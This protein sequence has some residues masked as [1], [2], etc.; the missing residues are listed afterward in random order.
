LILGEEIYLELLCPSFPWHQK[1]E[2][3]E[4]REVGTKR[5]KKRK[6]TEINQEVNF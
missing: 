3:K 5:G 1:K 4:V 6:I 2:R